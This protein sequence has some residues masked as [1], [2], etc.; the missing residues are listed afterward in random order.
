MGVRAQRLSDG[1]PP[2]R[3]RRPRDGAALPAA[4]FGLVTVTVLASAIFAASTVQSSSTR[5]R[6]S[7]ARALQLAENGLAHAVTVVRDTLKG[8]PFTR[9]LRGSDNIANNTDD[10]RVTGFAMSSGIT[11]PVAGRSFGDGSYTAIITDDDD[12]DGNLKADLNLRVRLRCSA[13]TRDGGNASVEVVLGQQVLPAIASNGDISISGNPAVRGYCGSVHAN[14]DLTITGGNTVIAATISAHD[15]VTGTVKDTLGN[16]KTPLAG[17]DTVSIPSMTYAQYCGAPG[18]NATNNMTDVA[19][20]LTSTGQVYQKNV[21]VLPPVGGKVNGWSYA[22]GTWTFNNPTAA[23]GKMCIEG[24][25]DVSGNVGTAL[26][27]MQ[28]TLIAT[29]SVKIAGTPYIAPA[30]TDSIM[31]VS[32]G[33]VW[34]S[35]NPTAGATSYE[36]LIYANSQCYLSGQATLRGQVL[37]KDNATGAGNTEY[38]ATTTIT[39]TVNLTYGCGGLFAR[40]MIYSWLQ[41]VE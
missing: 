26:A 22:G 37:C 13:T 3:A 23:P 36:G 28:W 34:V 20:W 12:G 35:G 39:G 32:G 7:S 27:P 30:T 10:G 15:V 5:N 19:F 11:I 17:R 1:V 31:I 14:D 41:R 24:N 21:G 29:G 25:V 16:V 4:L 9:L 8:Q 2:A 38:I 18:T 6:E 40:R 33:D